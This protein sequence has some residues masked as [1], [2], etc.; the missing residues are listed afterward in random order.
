VIFS[1]FF[2]QCKV[3]KLFSQSH[4]FALGLEVQNAISKYNTYTIFQILGSEKSFFNF[5]KDSYA[6]QGCSYLIKN[7][8]KT[9]I[10]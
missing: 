4:F 3:Q 5:S 1:F 6:H 7:T 2:V 9:E 10:M 8:V